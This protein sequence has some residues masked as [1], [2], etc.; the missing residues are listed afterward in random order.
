MSRTK[1]IGVLAGLIAALQFLPVKV[2]AGAEELKEAE[3]EVRG[4][5]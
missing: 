4:M 2:R 5:T 3:L 1:V